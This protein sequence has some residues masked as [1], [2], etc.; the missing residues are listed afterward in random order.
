M[1]VKE[2]LIKEIQELTPEDIMYI[3]DLVLDLRKQREQPV[4]TERP[5]YYRVQEIL[6]K[7]SGSFSNDI[8]ILREDRI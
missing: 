3:Y 2:R 5:A 4:K 7:C 6:K 1:H 8:H